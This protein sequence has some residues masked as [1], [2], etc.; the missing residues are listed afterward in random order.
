MTAFELLERNTLL[1]D[2]QKD[3]SIDRSIDR[4]RARSVRA[5]Y[6]NE[7][8]YFTYAFVRRGLFSSLSPPPFLLPSI[9]KTHPTVRFWRD[10]RKSFNCK[11]VDSDRTNTKRTRTTLSR[12]ICRADHIYCVSFLFFFA[13]SMITEHPYLFASQHDTF[14]VGGCLRDTWKASSS[15]DIHRQTSDERWTTSNDWSS[16]S[17]LLWGTVH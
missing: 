4:C 10:Q 13:F 2:E 9:G 7:D 15:L 6:R 11:I 8:N 5:K 1:S 14:A 17:S 16:S 12:F 3:R